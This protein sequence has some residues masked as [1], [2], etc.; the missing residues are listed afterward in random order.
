MRSL[1]KLNAAAGTSY[2]RWEQV[3]A[4]I[5]VPKQPAHIH[6]YIQT[7][8]MTEPACIGCPERMPVKEPSHAC[9]RERRLWELAQVAEDA[10]NAADGIQ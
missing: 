8:D 3:V 9:Y 7:G 4:A 1:K 10:M 5:K 6:V 2:T